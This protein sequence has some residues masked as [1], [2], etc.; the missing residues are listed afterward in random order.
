MHLTYLQVYIILKITK[1]FKAK[2][3]EIQKYIKGKRGTNKMGMR[4][5]KPKKDKFTASEN[6]EAKATMSLGGNVGSAQEQ[7]YFQKQEQENQKKRE[8]QKKAEEELKKAEEEELFCPAC[9]TEKLEVKMIN[10]NIP[11]KSCPKCQGSWIKH[12]TIE[13]LM[14]EEAGFVSKFLRIFKND[15]DKKKKHK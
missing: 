12:G 10:D 14:N 13:K 11:I 9:K 4:K 7:A 15:N 3:I 1:G 6:Y 5:D 8:E 2:K